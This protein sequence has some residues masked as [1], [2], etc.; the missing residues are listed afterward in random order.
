ML[1]KILIIDDDREIDQIISKSLIAE[2][3]QPKIA[4]DGQMALNLLKQE[5][6]DIILLDLKLPLYSGEEL[7]KII[8]TSYP[9]SDVIIITAYGSIQ[10]AVE[11]MK[12][13]AYDYILKPIN[14]DLLIMTIKRCIEK[15][16]LFEQLTDEK[17]LFQKVSELYENL[18]DLFFGTLKS[19]GDIIEA[20]D[21]YTGGHC[22]RISKYSNIIAENI[23]L[24]N[25]KKSVLR[26]AALL[27]DIG[28]ISI[29]ENILAKPGKLTESEFNLIK[30]HP[31]RGIQI[32]KPIKQLEDSLPGIK[33]HHERYDGK[34]YP[35]GIS[36]EKIPLIARILCISDSFDAMT[37][38][39]PYRQKMQ[40]K[41]AKEELLRCSGTQFDP[42]LVSVFT[43][44]I[45]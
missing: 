17:K 23:G 21:A 16:R 38:D 2:K 35:E 31:I 12:C 1:I 28:K 40:F 11:S 32:L 5:Q 41:E 36:G 3:F 37:S 8:K 45:S 13:G 24:S 22:E 44:F 33:Y 4:F 10:S 7:L 6:F 27:H 42:E 39:R 19:L 15:R 34:G 26:Y 9:Y 18:N 20:K 43:N 14:I 29:P 30:L 25:E